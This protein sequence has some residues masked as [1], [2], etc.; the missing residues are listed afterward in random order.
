MDK[1]TL[2]GAIDEDRQINFSV[3]GNRFSPTICERHTCPGQLNQAA[4]DEFR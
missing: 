3:I 4:G 2:K 1:K